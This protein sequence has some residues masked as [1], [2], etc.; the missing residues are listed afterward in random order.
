MATKK[1]PFSQRGIQQLPNDK[2][3]V[4]RIKTE[5]GQDNYIGVA[6][7]GRAEDRIGEHIGEIPGASVSIEQFDSIADARKKESNLIQKHQPKYNEE[8]K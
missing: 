2:P 6:K 8:G 7:R 5:G 1:V 4:Y 3:V